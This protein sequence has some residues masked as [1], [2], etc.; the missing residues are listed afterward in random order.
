[1]SSFPGVRHTYTTAIL[2]AG[3]EYH[4]LSKA[5]ICEIFK[6][7]NF[8]WLLVKEK[9]FCSQLEGKINAI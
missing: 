1:M 8:H 9:Y 4:K 3:A 2:F 6:F 7:L 5:L